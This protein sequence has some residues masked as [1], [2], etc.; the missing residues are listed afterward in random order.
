ML[1]DFFWKHFG[2]LFR[3]S[4]GCTGWILTQNHFVLHMILFE[5]SGVCPCR[6]LNHFCVT[7]LNW[8]HTHRLFWAFLCFIFFEVWVSIKFWCVTCLMKTLFIADI[9][10]IYWS[11]NAKSYRCLEVCMITESNK[12]PLIT[13]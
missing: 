2:I 9:M 11:A 12:T 7:C 5:G 8:K 10:F 4:L 6:I 1:C 13:F 3:F